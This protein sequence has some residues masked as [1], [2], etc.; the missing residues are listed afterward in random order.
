MP[1]WADSLPSKMGE[2]NSGGWEPEIMLGQPE[3]MRNWKP[4]IE[5]KLFAV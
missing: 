3:R 4:R 2:E 1:Y 5:T